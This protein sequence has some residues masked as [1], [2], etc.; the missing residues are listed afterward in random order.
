MAQIAGEKCLATLSTHKQ[1]KIR[2]DRGKGSDNIR[3]HHRQIIQLLELI[4]LILLL[5]I[6]LNITNSFLF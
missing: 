6:R 5:Q 4:G 1:P 3:D 2:E